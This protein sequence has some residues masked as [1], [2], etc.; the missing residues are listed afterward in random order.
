MCPYVTLICGRAFI[1]FIFFLRNHFPALQP[2]A[3]KSENLKKFGC[4]RS[5]FVIWATAR[6]DH[7]ANTEIIW[8]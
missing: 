6:P 2:Y 1:P 3:Q 7:F 5:N 8:V 4:S